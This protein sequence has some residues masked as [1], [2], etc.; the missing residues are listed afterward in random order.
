[1][2]GAQW[3]FALTVL[4]RPSRLVVLAGGV[5]HAVIL[6]LWVVTR[7]VGLGFVTGAEVSADFGVPDL[8]A[9]TFSVAVVGVAA[10]GRALH[11]T[12]PPV[13]PAAVTT[14]I[15]AVLLAGVVFL[16][17]PALLTRHDHGTS[18]LDAPSHQSSHGHDHASDPAGPAG[19]HVPL[20]SH[21]SDRHDTAH[22]AA[23]PSSPSGTPR[24]TR[25]PRKPRTDLPIRAV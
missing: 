14:R 20:H 5:L 19:E 25:K 1:M 10:I 3:V 13:V 17:V 2:G 22:P 24:V 4:R 11:E 16:T 15:K 6:A 12:V 8:V 23:A 9:N 7:T 21:S 18:P